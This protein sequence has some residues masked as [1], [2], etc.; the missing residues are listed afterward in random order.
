M[1]LIYAPF[2]IS[3]M[4][5]ILIQQDILVLLP[6]S[7][8][9]FYSGWICAACSVSASLWEMLLRLFIINVILLTVSYWHLLC[10]HIYFC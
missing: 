4:L 1:V 3:S 7:F 6:I 2:I 9:F 10:L 8:A 5:S